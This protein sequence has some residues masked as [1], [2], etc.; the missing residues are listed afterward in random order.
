VTR[1]RARP[2]RLDEAALVERLLVERLQE[3]AKKKRR[4]GYRLAHRELRRCG[5]QVNHKRVHRLWKRAGLSVPPPRRSRKRIRKACGTPR[6][7]VA[8][9]PNRVWC[10][11]FVEDRTLSGGKLRVLC[12]TDADTLACLSS[13]ASPWRSRQAVP[14]GQNEFALFWKG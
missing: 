13:R 9:R 12:V 14:S 4:R 3:I 11:D 7:L 10:L 2:A 1:C 6:C 8:D 5:W